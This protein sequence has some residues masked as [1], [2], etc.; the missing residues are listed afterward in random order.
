MHFKPTTFTLSVNGIYGGVEL[1]WSDLNDVGYTGETP[2]V[3]Y[4]VYKSAAYPTHQARKRVGSTTSYTITDEAPVNAIGDVYTYTVNAVST[5]DGTVIHTAR[6]TVAFLSQEGGHWY[7]WG[8]EDVHPFNYPVGAD[9]DVP[10]SDL[11]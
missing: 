4:D 1:R 6:V 11:P 2:V 8:D 5:Y 7:T 9:S 3:R 10:Y